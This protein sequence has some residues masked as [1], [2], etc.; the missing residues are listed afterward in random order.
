VP[1]LR[2]I[3]DAK[4]PD[5]IQV[6]EVLEF[7]GRNIALV[8]H[9]Q[10]ERASFV[11]SHL[12]F[13]SRAVGRDG[14]C[15]STN[16]LSARR[17]VASS[18]NASLDCPLIRIRRRAWNE[19]VPSIHIYVIEFRRPFRSSDDFKIRRPRKRRDLTAATESPNASAAS[20]KVWSLP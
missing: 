17:S 11:N 6:D 2:A 1:S 3:V 9:L 16:S 19:R 7:P 14:Q 4:S 10:N 18:G 8:V 12:T 13:A 5:H 20:C 15:I